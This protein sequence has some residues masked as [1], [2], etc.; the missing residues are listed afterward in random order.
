MIWTDRY[1][2]KK[3]ARSDVSEWAVKAGCCVSFNF[4]TGSGFANKAFWERGEYFENQPNANMNISFAQKKV[5]KLN[6]KCLL[7]APP[8]LTSPLLL[9]WEEGPYA[10]RW[11]NALLFLLFFIVVFVVVVTAARWSNALSSWL[12]FPFLLFLLSLLSHAARWFGHL[13]RTFLLFSVVVGFG[14]VPL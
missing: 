11:Y 9:C 10:A 5:N 8:W 2:D 1:A 4:R 7:L 13:I 3:F 6:E 14:F 12:L